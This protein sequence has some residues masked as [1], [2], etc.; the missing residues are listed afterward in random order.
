MLLRGWILSPVPLEERPDPGGD[1]KREIVRQTLPPTAVLLRYRNPWWRRRSLLAPP[2]DPCS[3]DA[4]D[5]ILQEITAV[6]RHLEA[7]DLKI[8]DLSAASTSIR[9]DR[10][11]FQVTVTDLDQRHT[12]VEDDIAAMPLQDT[13]RQFLRAK[14]TDLEDRSR[15]DNVHFFGTLEHK[16]GSD[17]KAFLKNFLASSTKSKPAKLSLRPDLKARTP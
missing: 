10:A 1:A 11:H 9:A 16:E 3:A 6:G 14:I 5:P 2:A 12:T 7:I 13:E 4:T 15:R 17:A 8:S